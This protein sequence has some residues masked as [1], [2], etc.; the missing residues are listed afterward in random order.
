MNSRVSLITLFPLL[1]VAG[2]S[3]G[4]RYK[5]PCV[6]VPEKFVAGASDKSAEQLAQWWKLFEDSCL[7]T[8]IEKALT[9]NYDLKIAI[10]RI[11]ET[12]ATYQIE[13]A[14]LFPQIDATGTINRQETSRDL[15]QNS[16][17]S[18]LRNRFNYFQA[19]FDALWELDFWGKLR[20]ARDAAYADYEAQ[21]EAMRDVRIILISDVARAYTRIRSL[22]KQLALLTHKVTVDTRLL[23]LTRDR[24]RSG[25]DSALPDLEQIAALESSKNQ[26]ILTQTSYKQLVNSLATLL[27]ENPEGWLTTPQGQC[28]SE[29]LRYRIPDTTKMLEAGIPSELL[30]RRPDIRQAE[31]L[32]AAAVERVGQAVADE[33]PSFS[34]VGSVATEANK[35]HDWF[36]TG[37]LSWLLGPALRWP[38]ITFGR[39]RFNIEAKESIQRQALLAYAQAVIQAFEDVENALIAYFQEHERVRVLTSKLCAATVER[40][41]IA[42]KFTSGLSSELDF[43]FAEKNRLDIALE[44]TSA[45]ESAS[46]ATIAVYKALGGGW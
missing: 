7:D 14:K 39:I 6:N 45:Q 5:K 35:S 43:L 16:I 28:I 37:S 15:I 18:D 46:T 24:L 32:Y 23:M 22:Q 33:F 11:E 34:L 36:S 27:G 2:C 3:V 12:R 40:D 1:L 38:L 44:L 26:I 9:S 29:D 13:R 4:P 8:L 21:I 41:L 31:R 19:G 30:K 10:E 17:A 25:V 42:G 20:H